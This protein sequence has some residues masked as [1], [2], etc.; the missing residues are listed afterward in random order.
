[1]VVVASGHRTKALQNAVLPP[2]R[3]LIWKAPGGECLTSRKTT[4]IARASSSSQHKHTPRTNSIMLWDRTARS[5]GH[6]QLC[7]SCL[8][9][10]QTIYC[11]SP[12]SMSDSKALR[13]A[14]F[15]HAVHDVVMWEMLVCR[16]AVRQKQMEITATVYAYRAHIRAA[17]IETKMSG[18]HWWRWR[19]R[20]IASVWWGDTGKLTT[21][22]QFVVWNFY[23]QQIQDEN[24][25]KMWYFCFVL[26]KNNIDSKTLSPF[27]ASFLPESKKNTNWYWFVV[28]GQFHGVCEAH[29]DPQLHKVNTAMHPTVKM[30][31]SGFG[32]IGIRYIQFYL[33]MQFHHF[34]CDSISFCVCSMWV[35]DWDWAMGLERSSK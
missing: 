25:I 2:S 23:L 13:F 6:L 17:V 20:W 35:W 19:W 22:W 10:P 31:F 9:A 26:C 33:S 11:G 34:V 8:S 24:S 16:V 29:S 5:D 3:A 14:P 12:R 1:M 28:W 18:G 30:E 15:S 27:T 32:G 4:K 21:I 7:L